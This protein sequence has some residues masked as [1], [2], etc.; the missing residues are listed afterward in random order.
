[1][2]NFIPIFPLGLVLYPGEQLNLHIFEPR[3]KQ[4]IKECF[5]AKKPFG[6]PAVINDKVSELG[7]LVNVLEITQTYDDGKMDIR[8]EGTEVFKILE[9]VKEIPDKL[10]SG[11]IVT[12]P[13]ITMRGSAGL[14]KK[15]L[16]GVR[17]IHKQLQ[18]DKDFKKPDEELLSYD[19]AHH[20]GLSLEDEYHLLELEQ[21]LHR[22]EFL[23]RHLA[24]VVPMMAEMELL[25][26]KIKLNGHFKNLEGF[27]F[28]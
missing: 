7:T 18:V 12:Y 28:K 16:A 10:Y 5:E 21:E 2:T 6:L 19:I 17:A 13:K 4:L 22:Q 24:K 1:M 3:Y 11:A 20:A 9:I 27:S 14:M 26:N 8:T 15:L 23:K 25:K